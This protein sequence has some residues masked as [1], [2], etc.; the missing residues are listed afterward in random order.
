MERYEQHNRMKNKREE[1]KKKKDAVEV[2]LKLSAVPDAKLPQPAEDEQHY[3]LNPGDVILADRGFDVADS[4]GLYNAE[5][6]IPAF[7][8]G[9]KQLGP[10]EL[11]STRGLALLR[12]HV[13]RV[14]GEVRNRGRTGV[15]GGLA[16]EGKTPLPQELFSAGYN[17]NYNNYSSSGDG[18]GGTKLGN[19]PCLSYVLQRVGVGSVP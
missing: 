15:D 3:G 11:E 2:L 1:E 14:I 10:L 17:P 9:K 6:K 4:V 16:W 7:T 12:I 13:E 8:K 19:G 18:R 5:L